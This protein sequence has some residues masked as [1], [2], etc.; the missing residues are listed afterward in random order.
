MQFCARMIPFL[1]HLDPP[2]KLLIVYPRR[3]ALPLGYI[4]LT[5]QLDMMPKHAMDCACCLFWEVTAFN[6]AFRFWSVIC[7]ADEFVRDVADRYALS[8]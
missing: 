6:V 4:H 2:L 7:Q 5:C 3:S 8:L 1:I